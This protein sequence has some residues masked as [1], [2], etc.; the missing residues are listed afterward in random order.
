MQLPIANL[1]V[2]NNFKLTDE[3]LVD[4]VFVDCPHCHREEFFFLFEE[5]QRTIVQCQNNENFDSK[6]A[7][8]IYR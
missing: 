4:N 5:S 1:V 3:S 6:F 8:I 2:L 7:Y